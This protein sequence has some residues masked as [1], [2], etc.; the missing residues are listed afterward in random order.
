MEIAALI[1]AGITFCICLIIF[2][3]LQRIPTLILKENQV[4]GA[5]EKMKNLTI[6]KANKRKVRKLSIRWQILIPAILLIISSC[7][8]LG[9][10]SKTRLSEGMIKMAG[11][12]AQ[13]VAQM[14]TSVIDV[15]NIKELKPG[16]ENSTA[17]TDTLTDLRKIKDS[18]NSE[19]I[20]TLCKDGINQ[21]MFS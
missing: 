1:F 15:T 16:S 9:N 13:I 21:F 12:Q 14:S 18:Y 11:A 17:Y 10:A 5:S 6:N 7:V 8:S 19:Y 20:Y 4:K 3:S 2:K